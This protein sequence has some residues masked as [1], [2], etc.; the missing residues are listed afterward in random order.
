MNTE[1]KS[2]GIKAY[3]PLMIA[4]VLVVSGGFYWYIEYT[5]YI[6]T[7][8][9]HIDSDNYAISSK[10]LGRINHIY[11]EEGDSV[12]KGALIAELDSTELHTQK[13]Q[14]IAS[15]QQAKVSQIQSEAKF[16]Y[17]KKNI[18]VLEINAAKAQEDFI[19]AKEQY[20]GDV[21]SKEQYDHIQKACEAAKAQLIASK[22][23][24]QVSHAQISAAIAAIETTKAQIEVISAQLKNTR[25][26]API[27]GIVA[28]KW[29]LD[30]DV[31]QPGQ[32]VITVTNIHKLWVEVYLEETKMAGLYLGQ[33]AKLEIDAYPDVTFMGKI[34]QM[35]S[36]TASQFSLIPP[37]NAS[38]NFTKTT[39]RVP[40]KISIDETEDHSP[41]SRYNLLAGMSVVVK[42]IK[43]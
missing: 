39:Q 14:A 40:L 23:Q 29:L 34:I 7:D 17:D 20:E 6:S 41:L 13:L 16:A 18:K 5:K 3:I 37:N 15:L 2:K 28:K 4:I 32:A 1:K 36:N 35:S 24:L 21:I 43:D 33:K 25:L 12:H 11:F 31:T 10:I 9:A 30:G 19:R 22:T 8:D 38:G 27:D 26:Y 42:I